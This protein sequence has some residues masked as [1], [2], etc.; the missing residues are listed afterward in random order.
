[1]LPGSNYYGPLTI[2]AGWLL[3]CDEKI[4]AAYNSDIGTRI[5]RQG[6]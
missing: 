4:P 1:L 5:F 3:F 2:S 6:A